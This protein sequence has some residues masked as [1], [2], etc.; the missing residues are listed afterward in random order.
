[1]SKKALIIGG[2]PAG[3]TCAYELLKNT[4]IIPVVIEQEDFLGGISRTATYLGNKMDMGG[5]RFFTKNKKV[6]DLWVELLP[7]QGEPSKDDLK[8]H[9]TN[10]TYIFGNP[11]P[12]KVDD[13]MLVRNRV[14]RIY[15]NDKFFDYPV[16]LSFQTI[17]N[18]G[19]CKTWKAGFIFLHTKF[20][21]LDESNLENF[22]INRFGKQLY[23]MFFESYTQKLWGVHPSKISSSWGAQRVKGLSLS[24]AIKGLF[25]KK[26]NE[27]SLIEQF[28]YPKYGP[29]HLF[30]KLANKVIEMGG[31]ILI[32]KKL[33]KINLDNENRNITSV[34]ILD[35]VNNN[36]ENLSFDYYISSMPVK[37]L[38]D[39]ITNKIDEKIRK[40][41]TELPYRDF[42]TVGLLL[43]NMKIKN[44]TKIPTQNNLIPDCWIY[45]QD[46][47]VKVGRIQVFNNWSPYMVKDDNKVFVGMEY[48]ATENDEMWNISDED[49]IN[50]AIDELVKLNFIY[51][52]SDVD[53]KVLYRVKKAYPAYFGSYEN[54]EDVKQFLLSIDNLYCIGRNGQHRYN[55]MD[56]SMLTA[57][58][59]VDAIL[60]K[61]SKQSVWEVN[62]EQEYH[63]ETKK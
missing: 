11:D 59:T 17:K 24:K 42:M 57:M 61:V 23:E 48:F 52:K 8:N 43:N 4:D 38:V 45:I 56:H 47:G 7:L 62:T 16:T 33:T 25:K 35:T 31:Q 51:S 53:E 44:Q 19:F 26:S 12:E 60:N 41:A 9:I 49:F 5:H 21:K 32:N 22:Y 20:K 29:G 54:F 39:S 14:S 63:E 46:K 40:I 27:T 3:L 15:Y 18:M 34:I 58:E 55:N 28:Y 50:D 6:S 37:N 36:S 2:G 13:V 30:E 10:K 1:M